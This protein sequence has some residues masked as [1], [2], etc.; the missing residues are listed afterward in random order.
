M[1]PLIPR[2]L[3]I[4]GQVAAASI[5]GGTASEISGGKFV[6]G[7][8]TAAFAAAYQSA[9]IAETTK[10]QNSAT[11]ED[12][13]DNKLLASARLPNKLSPD[14]EAEGL[15]TSFRVNPTSGIVTNYETYEINP[16]T[17]RFVP[18]LRFRGV[19]GPHGGI[20][21]PLVLRPQEGKNIGGRPVVPSKALS[22]ETPGP[23]DSI[24]KPIEPIE[25]FLP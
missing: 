2:G 3:G 1:S 23:R 6:N 7:A 12:G 17:G 5:I 20:A 13:S 15:H 10:A 22:H 24:V 9:A 21:P 11:F 4:R 16:V 25:P 18:T 14:L 8:T 19:G